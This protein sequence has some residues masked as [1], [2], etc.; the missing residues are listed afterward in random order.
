[1][2]VKVAAPV[3]E[4]VESVDGIILAQRLLHR[5]VIAAALP[6]PVEGQQHALSL[7]DDAVKQLRF[8]LDEVRQF[9]LES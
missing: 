3:K 9:E 7:P 1:M 6:I 8:I 2:L 5:Q 4:Q